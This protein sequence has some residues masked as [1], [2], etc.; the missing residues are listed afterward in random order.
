[1]DDE[2]GM[3]P[4]DPPGVTLPAV[5]FEAVDDEYGVVLLGKPGMR[6]VGDQHESAPLLQD[7]P[8]RCSR[9]PW[10]SHPRS[11]SHAVLS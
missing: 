3:I 8:S 2:Y 10:W 4:V 6:S 1:M 9:S 7:P 11:R 5:Y